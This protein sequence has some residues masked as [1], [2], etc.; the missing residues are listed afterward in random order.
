MTSS[1]SFAS[2]KEREAAHADFLTCELPN[3]VNYE[4]SVAGTLF[5]RSITERWQRGQVR[6]TC[7]VPATPFTALPRRSLTLSI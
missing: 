7:R 2:R 6:C 3:R 1:C 4:D 5:G